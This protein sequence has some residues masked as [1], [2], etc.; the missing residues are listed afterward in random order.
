MGYLNSVRNWDT[1]GDWNRLLIAERFTFCFDLTLADGFGGLEGWWGAA[2]TLTGWLTG[3]LTYWLAGW[4]VT[5]LLALAVLIALSKCISLGT[6]LFINL[7]RHNLIRRLIVL[8]NLDFFLLHISEFL[9]HCVSFID[10]IHDLDCL[11]H[12]KFFSSLFLHHEIDEII[13]RYEDISLH[14][15]EVAFN[16]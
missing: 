11:G 10:D 9:W 2:R 12:I 13:S 15:D 1:S 8:S 6:D 3:G 14:I 4:L 16:V 7:S 5:W